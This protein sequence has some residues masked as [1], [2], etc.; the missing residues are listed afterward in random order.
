MSAHTPIHGWVSA[1]QILG[2]AESTLKSGG[3]CFF[4]HPQIMHGCCYL[5]T[6]GCG[7]P[8][9]PKMHA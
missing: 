2:V 6:L 8:H 4:F 7:N 5:R 1:F 3:S 9:N